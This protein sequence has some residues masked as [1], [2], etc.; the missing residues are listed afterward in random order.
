MH[1]HHLVFYTKQTGANQVMIRTSQ[2]ENQFHCTV[3][4][5]KPY[6]FEERVQEYFI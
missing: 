4:T 3:K 1:L 5:R 6:D 2:A